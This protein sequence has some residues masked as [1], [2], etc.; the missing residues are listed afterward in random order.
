MIKQ[1]YDC[2]RGEAILRSRIQDGFDDRPP[3]LVMRGT[4]KWWSP[5]DRE[6]EGALHIIKE[7]PKN[8]NEDVKGIY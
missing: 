7:E 2:G 5:Y 8:V 3:T 4:T 1:G 6:K